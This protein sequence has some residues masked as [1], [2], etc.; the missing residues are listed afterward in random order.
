MEEI[1][2]PLP[3][4][5]SKVCMHQNVHLLYDSQVRR[6]GGLC[7]PQLSLLRAAGTERGISTTV[8]S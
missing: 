4:H 7:P 2:H 6:A 5:E 3:A 8:G 1:L